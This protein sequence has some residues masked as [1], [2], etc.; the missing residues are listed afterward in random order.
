[1]KYYDSIGYILILVSKFIFSN[2]LNKKNLKNNIRVW[3]SLIPL[4]RLIDKFLIHIFGK[5]LI[6]VINKS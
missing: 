4:S 2:F 5:S 6:C 3:N 1:M